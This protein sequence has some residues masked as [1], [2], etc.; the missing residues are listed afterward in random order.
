MITTLLNWKAEK[1]RQKVFK[2]GQLFSLVWLIRKGG[3]SFQECSWKKVAKQMGRFGYKR[4]KV[5]KT[6]YSSWPREK[7]AQSVSC[8]SPQSPTHRACE[9]IKRRDVHS[10]VFWRV[11][12]HIYDL[13]S[14]WFCG[15]KLTHGLSSL[16]SP[17]N[18]FRPLLG[19]QGLRSLRPALSCHSDHCRLNGYNT[20]DA[21]RTFASRF[22]PSV[23]LS[24]HFLRSVQFSCS[25]MSNSLQPHEPQHTRPPCPSPTPRVYPNSCPLSQWCHSAILSSVVPFSSCLQSFPASGSFEMSQLFAW[26]AKVLELQL[27]HQSFQWTLRTDLP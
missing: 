5:W 13:P 10:N 19:T 15:W 18:T 25:V 2:K 22:L 16:Q 1:A 21:P 20:D 24:P 11:K 4:W 7:M 23:T 14:A 9:N 12:C 3:Y 8:L 27:Q 17:A 26:G 6:E